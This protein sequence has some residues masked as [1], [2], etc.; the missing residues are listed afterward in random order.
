MPGYSEV[1]ER[2]RQRVDDEMRRI[3]REAHDEAV[4]L[5]S[6]NRRWLDGLCRGALPGGD[7]G[8]AGGIHRGGARAAEQRRGSG[9]RARCC[10]RRTGPRVRIPRRA[11]T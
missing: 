7:A 10:R 6:E 2:T 3:V 8:G 5:L 1:S 4:Q 11:Y 9:A